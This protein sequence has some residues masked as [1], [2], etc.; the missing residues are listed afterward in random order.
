MPHLAPAKAISNRCW[1]SAT[2]AKASALRSFARMS[3]KP[4]PRLAALARAAKSRDR[5]SPSCHHKA[6]FTAM[7]AKVETPKVNLCA[8]TE[9][10]EARTIISA[11]PASLTF[12]RGIIFR[13]ATNPFMT[14]SSS[15]PFLDPPN[16]LLRIPPNSACAESFL[17]DSSHTATCPYRADLQRHVC[18]GRCN[19]A[20]PWP[21]KNPSNLVLVT[22]GFYWLFHRHPG[23]CRAR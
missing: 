23:R 1:F 20:P 13:K 3:A 4:S 11:F 5:V 12:F 19:Y 21:R 10:S 8:Q 18:V 15:G 14:R 9:G 22:T 6:P 16:V 17:D 7:S 2:W